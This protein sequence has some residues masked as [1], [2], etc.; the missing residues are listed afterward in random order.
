MIERVSVIIS[1]IVI[2]TLLYIIFKNSR[3]QQKPSPLLQNNDR[4][5][6]LQYVPFYT[7]LNANER[8]NFEQ[9][10]HRFLS[11]VKITGVNTDIERLDELFIAASAIIPVFSFDNWEYMNLNE[12]LL[13]PGS[14]DQQFNQDGED[15]TRA[16]LVG[17]GPYQNV[18]VLS[19][20][21]LRAG[22][23]HTESRSNTGIH[24]FVHLIDKTDGAV[25]GI[26]ES[27]LEQEYIEAWH[28]L[29]L[30]NI[31]LIKQEQSDIDVYGA[32]NRAEFFAVISEYFFKQPE[33]L[34]HNHPELF[35]MLSRIYKYRFN[36]EK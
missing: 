35:S 4:N 8:A 30:Q 33:Q 15:R 25:D 14:F 23:L 13:Y 29:V 36:E 17:D 19:K 2:T 28:H 24:E 16:G 11:S 3:K 10:I 31:Q 32:T 26:P 21:E 34:Q 7:E 18:M 5:I 22:F 9:R 12:V 20:P 1:V 27:L 6:L